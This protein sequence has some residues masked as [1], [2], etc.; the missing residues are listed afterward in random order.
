M[1][2]NGQSIGEDTGVPCTPFT[3]STDI[4]YSSNVEGHAGLFS[5]TNP[6]SNP[7]LDIASISVDNPTAKPQTVSAAG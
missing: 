6:S 5:I 7:Q 1:T 3:N 2:F 4:S